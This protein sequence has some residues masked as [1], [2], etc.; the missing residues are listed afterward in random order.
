MVE[1]AHQVAHLPSGNHRHA[2]VVLAGRN[3]VHRIAQ[4]LHRPG[5]LLRQKSG[6]PDAGEKDNRRNEQQQQEEDGANLIARTEKLSIIGCARANAHHRLAEPLGHGQRHH[7]HLARR[8]CRNTQR[9]FLPGHIDHWFVS[10][11]RQGQQ[12]G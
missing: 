10:A 6:Q 8:G 3:L 4:R 12:I 5:N 11:L 2:M 7:Y 1:G 9:V